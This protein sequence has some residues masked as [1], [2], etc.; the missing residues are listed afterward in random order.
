MDAITQHHMPDGVS[1]AH[2]RPL[3]LLS[4]ESSSQAALREVGAPPTRRAAGGPRAAGLPSPRLPADFQSVRR[5]LSRRK[6]FKEKKPLC[7]SWREARTRWAWPQDS[8]GGPSCSMI[9]GKPSTRSASLRRPPSLIGERPLRRSAP[10]PMVSIHTRLQDE[11][12]PAP[13][14]V[15]PHEASG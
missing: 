9:G 13:D 6:V 8:A 15:H 7:S 5:R 3:R 4:S 10:P 2:A 14:G 1:P 11:V 12:S